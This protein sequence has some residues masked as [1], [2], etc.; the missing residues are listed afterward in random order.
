MPM[1]ATKQAKRLWLAGTAAVLLSLAPAHA[2]DLGDVSDKV[3]RIERDL[4]ELQFE[5]YK[6]NPP[7]ESGG[8]AGGPAGGVGAGSAKINDMEQSLRDLR[9]QVETMS[10]QVRQ[11]TEQLDIA[12]KEA[13]YR[14]GAL[15]GGAPAAAIPGTT[16]TAPM[17]TALPNQNAARPAPKPLG[18]APLTTGLNT[19]SQ[20]QGPKSGTL[21]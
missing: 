18:P 6:G 21:G 16:G 2:E 13:N 5:V 7:P 12:R 11:L 19:G 10:F 20:M 4:R 3:D 9:G 8:L 1:I 15:E 14:L 17:A